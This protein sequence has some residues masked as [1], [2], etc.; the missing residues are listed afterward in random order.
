MCICCRKPRPRYKQNVRNLYPPV[1]ESGMGDTTRIR[2]RRDELCRWSASYPRRLRD[3]ARYLHKQIVRDLDGSRW[4]RARVGLQ[5]L[6]HLIVQCHSPPTSL[7]RYDDL[8]IDA[9]ARALQ[10]TGSVALA[11]RLDALRAVNAFAEHAPSRRLLGTAT[12]AALIR[13]VAALLRD[14]TPCDACDND[15]DL[16]DLDEIA[17]DEFDIAAALRRTFSQES[18]WRKLRRHMSVGTHALAQACLL[19]LRK[20]AVFAPDA[21]T[22]SELSSMTMP[23]LMTVRDN[24]LLHGDQ[25]ETVSADG[26]A[27]TDGVTDGINDRIN[28]RINDGVADG[29]DSVCTDVDTLL[30][31]RTEAHVAALR[32]LGAGD[33]QQQSEK[34]NAFLSHLSLIT[35]R[36]AV[37]AWRAV[38]DLV[39]VSTLDAVLQAV[40][41]VLDDA[42]VRWRPHRFAV[43]CVRALLERGCL[44][45]A[46]LV[47]VRLLQHALQLE[48]EMARVVDVATAV[49]ATTPLSL[50]NAV[51]IVQ[52]ALSKLEHVPLEGVS[53]SAVAPGEMSILKSL[54]A[55]CVRASPR[56]LATDLVMTVTSHVESWLL[57]LLRDT[58][59]Y[60]LQQHSEEF[61]TELSNAWRTALALARAAAHVSRCVRSVRAEH[62]FPDEFV[63]TVVAMLGRLSVHCDALRATVAEPPDLGRLHSSE[64]ACEMQL[65]HTERVRVLLWR[66][67]REALVNRLRVSR[68]GKVPVFVEAFAA[69]DLERE[70]VRLLPSEHVGRLALCCDPAD[71]AEQRAEPRA[72]V[73]LR[74][75]QLRT[76]LAVTAAQRDWLLALLWRR[77]ARPLQHANDVA[78]AL[79]SPVERRTRTST[80]VAGLAASIRRRHAFPTATVERVCTLGEWRQMWRLLSLLLSRVPSPPRHVLSYSR[81]DA[82]R[83]AVEPVVR[84]LVS[85]RRVARATV[86][87]ALQELALSEDT[88]RQSDGSYV[89]RNVDVPHV[90][91]SAVVPS[92]R[93]ES[94]KTGRSDGQDQDGQDLDGQQQQQEQQQ[95]QG[96]T[97]SVLCHALDVVATC[98]AAWQL[99]CTL[100]NAD[101]GH[102]EHSDHNGHSDADHSDHNRDHYSDNHSDKYSD[103]DDERKDDEPSH[104]IGLLG[105]DV[106]ARVVA[107]DLL[108]LL[109]PR[110]CDL[111]ALTPLCAARAVQLDETVDDACNKLR[112]DLEAPVRAADAEMD[113]I[114]RFTRQVQA[115][116][117]ALREALD[118]V[119]AAE[120][121]QQLRQLPCF[122]D[123]EQQQ[124]QQQKQQQELKQQQK[125]EQKQQEQDVLLFDYGA[126]WRRAMKHRP[127]R[128]ARPRPVR[129]KRQRRGSL[130]T[131]SHTGSQTPHIG[132]HGRVSS[133]EF[134]SFRGNDFETELSQSSRTQTQP[135]NHS[136]NTGTHLSVPELRERSYSVSVLGGGNGVPAL[137]DSDSSPSPAVKEENEAIELSEMDAMARDATQRE[138]R[139]RQLLRE[140]GD[141]TPSGSSLHGGGYPTDRAHTDKAHT[142]KG[143][144][145]KGQA[146]KDQ[147]GKGQRS[148]GNALRVNDIRV[149][150][151]PSDEDIDDSKSNDGDDGYSYSYG[152]DDNDD[153]LNSDEEKLPSLGPLA[154]HLYSLGEP[155]TPLSP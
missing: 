144:T 61:E 122:A 62:V 18:E 2:R 123:E 136:G 68:Q 20:L 24:M 118:D 120:V 40:A 145:V 119:S 76:A 42:R 101:S 150:I 69:V 90:H 81:T 104:T 39:Q 56:S 43:F 32:R 126:L 153:E 102:S 11:V 152:Y 38:G 128:T 112:L 75:R 141:D 131:V 67:L 3:T 140:V 137:S 127:V 79:C 94:D 100:D 31:Q 77:L 89:L 70:H 14:P 53:E 149:V 154:S 30:R 60:A 51:G 50:G 99:L 124:P 108:R 5:A 8:A 27:D 88:R 66:L 64:R 147:T 110:G 16:G 114:E 25:S 130:T 84:F 49:V 28:N 86:D 155:R 78:A 74:R 21:L 55:V 71:D 57:P 142:D 58:Q 113:D 105:E 13:D 37:A 148:T 17:E 135:P 143:R 44:Q 129:T 103:K 35:T 15:V 63:A 36:Y 138:R 34:I 139:L 19:T 96:V 54:G 12:V 106:T 26:D 1:L 45:R 7:A 23:I 115:T 95:A 83:E 151:T 59:H 125:Q 93:T 22:L 133:D 46:D 48:G 85:L 65:R 116:L 33:V 109:R 47:V 4:L 97:A 6:T 41:S 91:G 9:C 146:D 132:T 134:S 72:C 87:A 80:R 117:G 52:L 121:Q 73:A 29:D 92:A 10:P 82:M 98:D 111:S 107:A